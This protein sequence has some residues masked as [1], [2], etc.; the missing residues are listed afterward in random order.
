MSVSDCKGGVASTSFTINAK[1]NATSPITVISPNGGETWTSGAKQ[2]IKWQDVNTCPVGKNCIALMESYNIKLS[3]YPHQ[4]ISYALAIANGVYGSSYSWSAGT[5]EN[6]TGT[7]SDGSYVIEVCQNG[8]KT[9]DKSDSYFKITTDPVSYTAP[10]L[11]ANEKEM[12][13][14]IIS[15]GTTATSSTFSTSISTYSTGCSSAQGYSI[16]TGQPCGAH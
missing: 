12:E 6:G 14:A 3:S 7:V 2:I 8:T 16:T 11:P 13:T 5:V 10:S 15:E 9:C 1:N 4:Q